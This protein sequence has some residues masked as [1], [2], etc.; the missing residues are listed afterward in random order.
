MDAA[1]GWGRGRAE[2]PGRMPLGVGKG[3]GVD[4]KPDGG[5]AWRDL[6]RSALQGH[7]RARCGAPAPHRPSRDLA[8]EIVERGHWVGGGCLE[9]AV[10]LTRRFS[11]NAAAAAM[12]TVAP[13][14]RCPIDPCGPEG[15]EPRRIAGGGVLPA[16]AVSGSRRPV[17]RVAW[18]GWRGSAAAGPI[19]VVADPLLA[20]ALGGP[21]KA[22]STGEAAACR[23]AGLVGDVVPRPRADASGLITGSQRRSRIAARVAVGTLCENMA[24]RGTTIRHA[25]SKAERS[26]MT[27]SAS[28]RRRFPGWADQ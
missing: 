10:K 27:G 12:E 26:F 6:P 5:A 23:G 3:R 17:A 2:A 16:M 13:L 25:I 4:S 11:G 8:N 15:P 22:S 28:E 19:S 1:F 20:N 9:D 7:R 14:T 21:G 18:R 24:S